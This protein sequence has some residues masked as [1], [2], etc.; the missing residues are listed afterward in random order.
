M[1]NFIFEVNFLKI[2][3]QAITIKVI[4]L[5]RLIRLNFL[6]LIIQFKKYLIIQLDF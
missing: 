1:N 5:I 6:F 3:S 4:H 2:K